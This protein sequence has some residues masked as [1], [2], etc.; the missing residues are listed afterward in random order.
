M[1]TLPRDEKK[2]NI[3]EHFQEQRFQN[4][5]ENR[6]YEI[7]LLKNSLTVRTETTITRSRRDSR[8]QNG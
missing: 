7:M 2:E 5:S 4:S 8:R 1:E 3:S 6:F